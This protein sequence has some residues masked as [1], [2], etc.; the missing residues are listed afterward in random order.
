MARKRK[1]SLAWKSVPCDLAALSSSNDDQGLYGMLELCELSG[2]E[3]SSSITRSSTNYPTNMNHKNGKS[4]TTAEKNSQ[5]TL[6]AA[7]GAEASAISGVAKKNSKKSKKARLLKVNNDHENDDL[8]KDDGTANEF[9]EEFDAVRGAA[10]QHESEALA[11]S[12]NFEDYEAHMGSWAPFEFDPLLLKGLYSLGFTCPTDIQTRI[13]PKIYRDRKD[14]IAA[15]QTGSGKTLAFGLPILN[16]LIANRQTS[17]TGYPISSLVISP[18]REL[19]L[20]IVDHLKKAAQFTNVKIV[21]CVGGL[22][23]PK[24]KRLLSGHPDIVVATPGRLWDLLQYAATENAHDQRILDLS[25][26]QFLVIDEADRMVSRG[27]YQELDQILNYI[28]KLKLVLHTVL[29]SATLTHDVTKQLP[30]GKQSKGTLH[31]L[32]NRIQ[33]RGRPD[34]H[35]LTTVSR[36]PKDVSQ[37]RIQC[38]PEQ[39]DMYLYYFLTQNPGRSIVFAN[40]I[41][42]VRRLHS[43]LVLLEIPAYPLHASMQQRQRLK[44]LDRLRNNTD[45]VLICTDVAA[46][47]LDVPSIDHVI[48]YQISAS[49]DVYIHRSGRT[50]RASKSGLSLMLISPAEIAVYKRQTQNINDKVLEYPVHNVLLK[51]IRKRVCLAIK[52][53]KLLSVDKKATTQDNWFKKHAEAMELILDDDVLRNTNKDSRAEKIHEDNIQSLRQ[54]LSAE[55]KCRLALHDKSSIIQGLCPGLPNEEVVRDSLVKNK[56]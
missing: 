18:T 52:I 37:Y 33:F 29:L 9:D 7:G 5:S 17:E 51:P 26:L 31:D 42:T 1:A 48:H 10:D 11:I 43:I 36:I 41:A 32:I 3:Y 2:Q 38:L 6:S 24:Q 27:H 8:A 4:V 53:D 56:Q 12:D 49:S 20:Q 22:A 23:A 16:R 54:Q 19:A 13:I 39:K 28:Y 50:G 55:L 45:C 15:A 25:R 44:N 47:G 34:I 21:G 40:S 30:N 14:I 46:R 35:D